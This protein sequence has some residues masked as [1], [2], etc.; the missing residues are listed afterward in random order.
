MAAAITT[1]SARSRLEAYPFAARA[2]GY[3]E[4]GCRVQGITQTSAV[5]YGEGVYCSEQ[6]F[7]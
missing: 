6:H 2:M 4:T 5:S 7:G 1:M 3:A